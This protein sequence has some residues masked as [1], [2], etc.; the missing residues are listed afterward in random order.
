MKTATK[1]LNALTMAFKH[2]TKSFG[3]KA[4]KATRFGWQIGPSFVLLAILTFAPA[5]PVYY[6][7]KHEHTHPDSP[8]QKT[9]AHGLSWKEE[10]QHTHS[11]KLIKHL[12]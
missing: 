4:W 8:F 11:P 9:H 7:A 1:R 2:A 3:E 10:E 12:A 5:H 6:G